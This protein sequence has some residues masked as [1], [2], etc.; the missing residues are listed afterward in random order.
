M[1]LPEY[2]RGGV[3]GISDEKYVSKYHD[4][5]IESDATIQLQLNGVAYAWFSCDCPRVA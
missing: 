1:G 4:C 2:D 3:P 5:S